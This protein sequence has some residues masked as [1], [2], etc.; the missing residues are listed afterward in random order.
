MSYRD[1]IVW[2]KS[3]DLAEE[4]YVLTNN[5]S[6]HELYGLTNQMRRAAVSIPSN[7]AEGQGR[8]S[9]KEFARFL[10]I[11]HG[12]LTELETQL[13]LSIRLGYVNENQIESI[14]N[15]IDEIGR[16]LRT[17]MRKYR[18]EE[19]V[20]KNKVLKKESPDSGLQTSVSHRKDN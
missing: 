18:R 15:H 1:L 6:K 11:A 2:K 8:E 20:N 14:R 17:L 5:Y 9:I 19:N 12:S 16:M 7:I 13:L 4:I 3:M 10:S